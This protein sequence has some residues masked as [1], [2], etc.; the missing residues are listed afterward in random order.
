MLC[1]MVYNMGLPVKTGLTYQIKD[2]LNSMGYSFQAMSSTW[3]KCS[4][5][6]VNELQSVAANSLESAAKSKVRTA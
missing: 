4:S 3:V 2:E 6:C 1:K 5:P